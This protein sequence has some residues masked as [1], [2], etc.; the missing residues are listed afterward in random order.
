MVGKIQPSRTS[1]E[2][3][4][5]QTRSPSLPPTSRYSFNLTE[6]NDFD[7]LQHIKPISGGPDANLYCQ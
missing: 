5:S 2:R 7:K 1:I 3:E 4:R 6:S